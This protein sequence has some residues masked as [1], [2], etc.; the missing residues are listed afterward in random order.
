[1]KGKNKGQPWDL[2]D[3]GAKAIKNLEVKELPNLA[4]AAGGIQ[5]GNFARTDQSEVFAKWSQDTF[6]E[7]FIDGNAGR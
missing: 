4:L 7:D 1:M 5:R 6:D 2:S 3:E